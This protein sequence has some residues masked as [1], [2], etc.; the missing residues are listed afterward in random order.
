LKYILKG[1]FFECGD[2]AGIWLP[3]VEGFDVASPSLADIKS[4]DINLLS[5]SLDAFLFR[6]LPLILAQRRDQVQWHLS[7]SCQGCKFAARCEEKTVETGRLGVIPNLS[8][9][10][11][12]VLKD[13]LHLSRGRMVRASE[14]LTDIEE[15]DSLV[16]TEGLLKRL[17]SRNSSTVKR[18]RQ[19]LAIPRRKRPISG[20]ASPVVA[21]AIKRKIQVRIRA[22]LN[23]LIAHIRTRSFR[24]SITPVLPRRT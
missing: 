3:P 5:S 15:L 23:S 17:S 24:V 19:L 20:F 14:P 11:A 21:A 4:I 10:D 13:L 1:L 9:E 18:A 2:N 8:V 22:T 6:R 7:P 16:N 12:Q